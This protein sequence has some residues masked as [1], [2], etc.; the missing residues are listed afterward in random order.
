MREIGDLVAA[1]AK[2]SRVS[3]NAVT[4]PAPVHAWADIDLLKQAFLNIVMNGIEAMPGGGTLS[5]RLFRDNAAAILE[6]ED[7]GGGIPEEI[8]EKIFQL[9]F[10]TKEKGSGIG[11]AVAYQAIQLMGGTLAMRSQVGYGTVFRIGLPAVKVEMDETRPPKAEPA[12]E[13]PETYSATEAQ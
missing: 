2:R 3:I 12:A 11:L 4:P 7:R 9:Y 13:T 5:L 10:S 8:Q 1:Q 6:I